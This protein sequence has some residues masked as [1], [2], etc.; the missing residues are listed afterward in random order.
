MQ[1]IKGLPGSQ[2]TVTATARV[3]LDMDDIG[4]FEKGDVLV[5]ASTSPQWT[6]IMRLASAIV[7][8][9]GGTLS[10]AAIVSREFGIP[11]VVGTQNATETIKDGQTVTVNGTDGLVE[12]S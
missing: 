8:D 6:P 1:Q 12:I 4:S 3:I 11:A 9:L 5:T 2:G 7:T 10:H